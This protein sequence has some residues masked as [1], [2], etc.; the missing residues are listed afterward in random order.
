M[1]VGIRNVQV[2]MVKRG[3]TLDNIIVI[4]NIY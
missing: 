1:V 3:Q 4:S 2:K